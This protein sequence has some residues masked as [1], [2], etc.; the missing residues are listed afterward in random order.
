[1]YAIRSHKDSMLDVARETWSENVADFASL[2][3]ELKSKY[4]MQMGRSTSACR[5]F[6]ANAD[7]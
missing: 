2:T 1:M 6:A 4:K 3:E 7:D 5:L